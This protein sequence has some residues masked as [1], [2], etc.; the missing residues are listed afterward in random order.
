[1]WLIIALV[2]GQTVQGI[3]QQTWDTWIANLDEY[4]LEVLIASG[5]AGIIGYVIGMAASSIIMPLLD[6]KARIDFTFNPEIFLIA[7]MLA[8]IVGI[9]AAFYP[10]Y[11]ATKLDPTVAFRTL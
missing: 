10:A 3:I 6:S 4:T 5:V 9:I 7:T 8:I 2:T 11:K 1:M